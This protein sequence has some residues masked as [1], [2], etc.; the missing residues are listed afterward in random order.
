MD[1]DIVPSQPAVNYR[2]KVAHARR[3]AGGAMTQAVKAC[4]FDEAVRNGRL[5]VEADYA[6]KLRVPSRKKPIDRQTPK[7][8]GRVGQ[9]LL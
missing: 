6:G 3:T 4:L 5:V 1:G 9:E 8:N 2:R 7:I